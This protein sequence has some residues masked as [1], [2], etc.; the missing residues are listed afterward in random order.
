M[1]I[2][3]IKTEIPIKGC[4]AYRFFPDDMTEKRMEEK[5]KIKF[6]LIYKHGLKS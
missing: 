6:E 3:I 2:V 4:A 1:K 5:I